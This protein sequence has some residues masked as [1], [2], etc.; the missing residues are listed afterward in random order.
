MKKEFTFYEFVGIISP[1]VVF[2]LIIYYIFPDYYRAA[3]INDLSIG[4]LGI[5]VI[6]AY[7]LGHLIQSIGNLL[8]KIWWWFFGGMPT[9]WIIKEG[10]KSYLSQDQ[11]AAVPGNISKVLGIVPKNHIT[12]YD[13]DEWFG[14]TRQV[15]AAVKQAKA[16]DRVDTF[17]GNYGFFR[18]IASSLLAG[19]LVLI[20]DGG[21]EQWQMIAIISFFFVCAI[22]RMHRFGKHYAREL[23]VQFL[24]IRKNSGK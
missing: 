9:N 18:G 22:A 6:L 20:V 21:C 15:Y 17:N 10:K 23:F 5:V 12:L 19:L 11:I 14:I 4:G 8:E 16:A 24:Q 13:S 7:V 2:L 1:G 3:N